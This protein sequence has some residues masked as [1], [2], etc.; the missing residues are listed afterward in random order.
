MRV[1]DIVCL[2]V[3]GD[4]VAVGGVVAVVIVGGV[5]VI[6]VT[7]VDCGWCCFKGGTPVKCRRL[8]PNDILIGAAMNSNIG[9]SVIAKSVEQPEVFVGGGKLF[10]Q[11]GA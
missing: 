2:L 5:A 3:V 6:S 7:V 4:G 10:E 9:S 11:L 1:V 8:D